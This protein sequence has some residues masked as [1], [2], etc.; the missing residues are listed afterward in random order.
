MATRDSEA[1]RLLAETSKLAKKLGGNDTCAVSLYAKTGPRTGPSDRVVN[2]TPA[3]SSLLT[4]ESLDGLEKRVD[5]ALSD[6]LGVGEFAFDS[7]PSHHIN[8]VKVD[9]LGFLKNWVANRPSVLTRQSFDGDVKYLKKVR[10]YYFDIYVD[11]AKKSITRFRSSTP[12]KALRKGVLQAVMEKDRYTRLVSPMLEFDN[13]TDMF[14][15]EG[16]LFILNAGSF[17]RIVDCSDEIKSI[18]KGVLTDVLKQIQVPNAAEV[19]S[20][21]SSDG[22]LAKKVVTIERLELNTSVGAAELAKVIKD[23][24]IGLKH[25]VNKGKLELEL[26][27]EDRGQLWSF[28]RLISLDHVRAAATNE[29]FIAQGG[30]RLVK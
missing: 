27:H 24:K 30:K 21:I 16:F 19:I 9:D 17:D 26:D 15:F 13:Q 25:K 12:A 2:V 7:M 6:P 3:L 29:K 18:A 5:A 14:L 28:L 1:R 10:Y 23:Y 8:Y 4:K 22:Q 11:N 20:K